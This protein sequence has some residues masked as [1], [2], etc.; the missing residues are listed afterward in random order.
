MIG[1]VT[2]VQNDNKAVWVEFD[3][4]C[5]F[6][7][8]D[9]VNVGK[10]RHIRTLQQNRLYWAFLTWL[11]HPAGGNLREQGHFSTNALHE[12]VKAWIESE[13]NHDFPIDT[14]F[15]TAE[16]ST[17]QFN[18][19]I[20][21]VNQELFVEILGVDTSGFWREYERFSKW[22]EYN[23]DDMKAYMDEIPF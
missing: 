3:Q 2:V 12:D 7:M 22:A 20:D 13:H 23:S 21:L 5:K 16:L 6:R 4:P 14:K 15:S 8:G 19:F 11:I 10:K 1:R 17:K 18:E 9:E